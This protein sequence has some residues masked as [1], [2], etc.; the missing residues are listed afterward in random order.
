MYKLINFLLLI[1]FLSFGQQ[2]D[3]G[4]LYLTF[5]NQLTTHKSDFKCV[6]NKDITKSYV[7]VYDCYDEHNHLVK[8]LNY[9]IRLDYKV[10]QEATLPYVKQTDNTG[11]GYLIGDMKNG[12]PYNGFFIC[13]DSGLWLMFDFYLNGQRIWQ[14]YNDPLKTIGAKRTQT[15]YALLNERNV[16][17]KDQL[18]SGVAIT[19]VK[20][21][22][23]DAE[24][25]SYVNNYKTTGFML[26]FYAEN[27]GDFIKIAPLKNSYFLQ[28]MERNSIKVTYRAGGRTIAIFDKQG[29]PLQVVNMVQFP[30]EKLTAAQQKQDSHYFKKD[31]KT[32]IEQETKHT[33]PLKISKAHREEY[34]PILTQLAYSLYTNAPL[35]TVTLKEFIGS[36]H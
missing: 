18:Q 2:P 32:Y 15:N 35:D 6:L 14:F 13:P 26:M 23:A 12:K 28:S 3:K 27:F 30:S 4:Q 20:M 16:F 17:I 31:N 21:N 9:K 33:K 11:Y 8:Q 25:I 29:K 34:S 36:I 5:N 24:I 1:P 7:R 22:Q 10:N 19:Q